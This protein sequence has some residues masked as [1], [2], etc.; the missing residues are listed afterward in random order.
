MTKEEFTKL[1]KKYLYVSETPRNAFGGTKLEIFGIEK[2]YKKMMLQGVD[3]S[4]RKTLDNFSELLD[5]VVEKTRVADNGIVYIE[6]G[7][8]MQDV[9]DNYIVMKKCHK[10][11][12]SCPNTNCPIVR[13]DNG[14][15]Y[16]AKCDYTD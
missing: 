9:C 13:Y 7:D 3:H 10:D 16:C 2:L 4:K 6:T 15:S 12:S 8:I 1:A 14:E 11:Q 5:K